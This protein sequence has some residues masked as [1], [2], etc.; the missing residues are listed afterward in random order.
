[1]F[2][3]F[4]IEIRK[5]CYVFPGSVFGIGI[6]IHLIYFILNVNIYQNNPEYIL[7][8]YSWD[9]FPLLGCMGFAEVLTEFIHGKNVFGWWNPKGHGAKL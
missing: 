9:F 5:I 6:E 8:L 4:G 1:M 3:L 7:K 2:F